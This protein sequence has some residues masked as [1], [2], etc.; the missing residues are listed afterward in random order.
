M[1]EKYRPKGVV[2]LSVN[3]T[4]DKVVPA[5]KFADEYHLPFPVGRELAVTLEVEGHP[6]FAG[7]AGQRQ[8][9][10]AVEITAVLDAGG[11]RHV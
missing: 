4:W 6:C 3:V 1:Y 2:F 11:K 5:M 9:R 8:R 10:R 7:R